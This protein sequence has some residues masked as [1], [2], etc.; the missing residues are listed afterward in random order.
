MLDALGY[1]SQVGDDAGQLPGM[2]E[3]Y[4]LQ[5]VSS[6][7]ETIVFRGPY[8]VGRYE[9]TDLALR[10]LVIV[11]LRETGHTGK[12]VAECFSLSEEYV[13][14]LRAR[15]KREGSAALVHKRGRPRKLSEAKARRASAWANE[16]LSNAEIARR[17][18]VHHGTIGRLLGKR[19]KE[20]ASDAQL[21]L[22]NET[23]DDGDGN[24]VVEAR[25]DAEAE[26]ADAPSATPGTTPGVATTGHDEPPPL[27]VRL[28]HEERPSR[29]AGAML[30]HAFLERLGA[31]E[32]LSALPARAARR[33]DAPALVLCT[34]F[35]FALGISSLE[36]AKHLRAA[37]A[38][39][40]VG[41]SAF[42]HLRT[43]RPRLRSLA[44]V[45]DPLCIQRS[46]AQGMLASDEAPPELFYVDD[47]FVT[48]WGT[49][50]LQK[51]YN[52]RRHLA[53]PGR[54]D[55]FVT[56]SSWRAICFSSGE[57][58]GLSVT[59]PEVLTELKAIVGN[60]PVMVGFDRG[61]SYPKVFRALAEA[62]MEWVTWRRAPLVDPTVEARRSWVTVEGKRKTLLIADERV[63]LPD[64][65]ATPVRQLS[66]FE[67]GK[68]AFQVL[69]SNTTL[70][71]APLVEKLRGRWRIENFNKYAEAHHGIHWLCT[72]E[73]D[74]ED[75]T[76]LVANPQRKSA[77]QK[78]SAA[79]TALA[80]AERRLGQAMEEHHESMTARIAVISERRDDV[81]LA[82]D[83]LE[84][85][86]AAMKGIPAKLPK[87]VLDPN[88]KRAKPRLAARALQ[89]VCR[90]LAYNAELDL[91]RRLNT[92]L[93]DPDEYRSIAR[94]LLHLGGAVTYGRDAVT[95]HL[96]RPDAPRVAHALEQLVKE[97]N[98]GPVVRIA[99]DR[100]PITYQ[101][102]G[103]D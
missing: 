63:S 39:A 97:L 43:L 60:R 98:A 17:L 6:N 30:L 9:D 103:L 99:G 77:R 87:N 13:A 23:P 46:F 7:G 72:Y 8:M 3:P 85:A 58:R 54:D 84:E 67:G 26:V 44:Q 35:A 81:T 14:T 2:P 53:E 91:A 21:D 28:E 101:M 93:G 55:T 18:G 16:G 24:G 27:P 90:L 32:V 69:S 47:H 20:A 31:E 37:D 82:K 100:R 12:E 94:N 41:L 10:N 73:M 59:L 64:Y 95:V 96:E 4:R 52:I 79:N 62:D 15:A 74:L 89:M 78:R 19:V 57:P 65:D 83:A 48:Y 66:A 34:T 11:S 68:V 76:A 29:Y 45:S 56:D 86:A 1:T 102:A 25:A 51:G 38:G 80:E 22:D 40:L 49:R 88:A 92:Y 5:K 75:D 50:P 70:R 42:P 36:G 33:Y 61:G 71:P